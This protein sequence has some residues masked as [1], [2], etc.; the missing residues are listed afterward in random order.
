MSRIDRLLNVGIDE[1]S[2]KDIKRPF[3][4]NAYLGNIVLIYI[5]QGEMIDGG[6]VSG[7]SQIAAVPPLLNL[8]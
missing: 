1:W 3:R 5:A 2:L 6:K 4:C 7:D 8:G